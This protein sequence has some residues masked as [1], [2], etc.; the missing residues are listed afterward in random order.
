MGLLNMG[1]GEGSQI[2]QL[3]GRGVRLKGR[4]WSLKRSLPNERPKNLFLDKLETLNIFGINADYMETFRNYL[5]AEDIVTPDEMLTLDFPVQ[6]RLPAI[7]LKTLKLKDEVKGN[8]KM[9][10]KRQ[11]KGIYLFEVPEKWQGKLKEIHIALDRYPKVQS[12]ASKGTAIAKSQFE[13]RQEV[14]LNMALFDFFDWD[15]IYLAVQAVK[16]EKTWYNLRL[17]K[18]KL[19][20]FAEQNHWYTLYM[21]KAALKV[22]SF[23]HI[24]LQQEILIDLLKEYSKQFYERLKAAYEG[25]HYEV[26]EVTEENGSMLEKYQFELPDNDDGNAIKTKLEQLAK[27]LNLLQNGV[28]PVFG[29]DNGLQMLCFDG[30]LFAPIFACLERQDLP[31]NI[32]PLAVN[33]ESEWT[34][35]H[36]LIEA[37]DNGNLHKW[38]QSKDVYLLRNAANKTKGLGFA[39]AGNFYPDFLLWLVDG[40]TGEQWLSLID[41]KGIR[42]MEQSDPK[43]GLHEELQRFA[44]NLNIRQPELSAFILSATAQRDLH[45]F[46][47]WTDEMFKNKHILFMDESKVYLKLMFDMMLGDK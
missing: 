5:A 24:A 18:T 1:K 8:R 37:K 33:A 43:F 40:K 13:Q 35:L 14:K 15:K 45:N 16:H 10:F 22:D 19:R 30:H 46:S 36:H 47:G 25:E 23:S 6:K 3:F 2:I 29:G 32:Q 42:N 9:S 38:T 44:Q 39:L 7:K 20:Q 11:E 31:F 4:D 41:P 17:D 26:V 12:V 28:E 34:L 21:P 27:G